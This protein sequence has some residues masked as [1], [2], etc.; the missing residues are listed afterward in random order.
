M[1]NVPWPSVAVP[2]GSAS[3]LWPANEGIAGI[4]EIYGKISDFAILGIFDLLLPFS[5][6]KWYP[7]GPGDI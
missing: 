6:L 1:S 5:T 2:L 3:E 7:G 4:S